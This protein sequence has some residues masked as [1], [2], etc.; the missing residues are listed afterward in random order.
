L[1]G[2]AALG[3]GAAGVFAIK[4]KGSR[5]H[6][7]AGM[8]AV[9]HWAAD[10]WNRWIDWLETNGV[11]GWLGETGWPNNLEGP[12]PDLDQWQ[13]LGQKVYSWADRD[14][15]AITAWVASHASGSTNLRIYGPERSDIG[16]FGRTIGVAHSQASV[17]EAHPTSATYWRGM[18]ANGGELKGGEDSGF[19][20]T[21]PGKYGTQYIYPDRA[22]FDYLVGRGHRYFRIPF[23]WE[24]LQPNLNKALNSTEVAHLN[25]SAQAAIDAGHAAGVEVAVAID[26][27][28]FGG[29]TFS[30][31]DY[32]IG[33]G[34]VPVSAFADFWRR[35]SVEFGPNPNVHYDI[36]NEPSFLPSTSQK[37]AARLWEEATQAA[38]DAIRG[39]GDSTR[40]WVSGYHRGSSGKAG[41]FVFVDH[42]PKAWI[43]G[44]S[45]VH[46][47]THAYW[48]RYGYG[49]LA[50]SPL[51]YDDDNAHWASRGY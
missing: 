8:D 20:N 36:M 50:D 41:L 33:T 16:Y 37:P 19:S 7:P 44:Q 42:H 11:K 14:E 24:R 6:R 30:S 18:N 21:N 15:V 34:Q 31:G 13:T 29:Y 10:H 51:Y 46:Y 39:T 23:R 25:A 4:G 48:G 17:V 27:H 22:D 26:A 5:T 49:T 2:L 1:A 38:V 32:K 47:T 43:N 12:R 40:I 28:N 35:M 9:T 45:N 3:A